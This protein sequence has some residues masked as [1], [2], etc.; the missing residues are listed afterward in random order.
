MNKMPASV[1]PAPASTAVALCLAAL[2]SACGSSGSIPLKN[3]NY[4]SG[5]VDKDTGVMTGQYNP[6][7]YS[8]SQVKTVIARICEGKRLATYS[9]AAQDTLRAFTLTCRGGF[10][11][12]WGFVSFERTARG[13][14]MIESTGGGRKGEVVFTQAEVPLS[15]RGA[16]PAPVPAATPTAEAPAKGQTSAARPS[17]TSPAPKCR[18]SITVYC[19]DPSSG[20]IIPGATPGPT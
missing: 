8:T 7:G 18:D 2:V 13:T 17:D 15:G 19:K 6:A 1:F 9:E 14:V 4:F 20:R 16:A 10:D 3:P 5:R 12:K 11:R